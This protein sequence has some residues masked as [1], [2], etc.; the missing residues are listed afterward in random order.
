MRDALGSIH[1][2]E[3]GVYT[4]SVE[5]PRDPRTGKRRRAYKTVRGSLKDAERARAKL[6]TEAGKGEE[7]RETIEMGDFWDN[8]YYPYVKKRLRETTVFGYKRKY[9]QYIE[10]RFGNM[11]I[12]RIEPIMIDRWLDEYD[13]PSKR[14]EAYKMLRQIL[15]RAVRWNLLASNPCDRVEVPKKPRYRPE[16]LTA[17]EVKAY[18]KHFK[19]DPVEAGVLVALGGG[20]RR[21]E[22][23]ALDWKDITLDGI[24]TV[25][26]A[27]TSIGGEAHDDVP[28]TEFSTRRVHLPKFVITRLNELRDK[29]PLLK[30][31]KGERMHPEKFSALFAERRNTLPE[32]IKRIPLKNLRHT[33]LTMAIES[34]VD[35]LAV[36]RRAGHSNVSITSAYYVR[37][38]DSVD[39]AAA[40]AMDDFLSS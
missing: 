1:K 39:A 8:Y 3:N 25:D 12:S 27:I 15:A 11:L 22:I 35:L 30:S 6:L 13:T 36:S 10:T 4:V 23:V 33:S 34:G 21:S 17:Q 28:K 5:L 9:K 19:D 24:I 29:G 32:G 31:S 26:N 18:I 38:H 20:L 7:V 16:V 14:F 2:D 40:D 37:P